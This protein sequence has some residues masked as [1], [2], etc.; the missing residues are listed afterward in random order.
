ML[1]NTDFSSPYKDILSHPPLHLFEASSHSMSQERDECWNTTA[2]G[3]PR[4]PDLYST[5]I[6]RRVWLFLFISI[7]LQPSGAS[8]LEQVRALIQGQFLSHFQFFLSICDPFRFQFSWNA[9][10][11][12]RFGSA[13]STFELT[14]H[15]L[16]LRDL[17]L[18]LK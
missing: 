6:Y 17:E 9:V 8:T 12:R 13:E 18:S 7:R 14:F 3:M 15:N 11:K 10:L 1:W 16:I 2:R 4:I 5:D